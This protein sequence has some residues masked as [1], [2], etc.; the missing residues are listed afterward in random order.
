ML[1]KNVPKTDKEGYDDHYQEMNN[2]AWSA[3]A[4]SQ[5]EYTKRYKIQHL[6]PFAFS[7]WHLDGNVR[8]VAVKRLLQHIKLSDKHPADIT[9]LDAGSGLGGLS[10]FLACYGYNV[11]GVEISEVG[12]EQ[13]EILAS[14]FDVSERCTFLAESLEK[15]SIPDI[16]RFYYWPTYTSPLY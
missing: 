1:A 3:D 14:K 10:V 9:I 12:C 6:T 2:V 15:T 16:H 13:A 11:I 4:N 8:G 7:G 5:E